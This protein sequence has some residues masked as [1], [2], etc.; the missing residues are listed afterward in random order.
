VSEVQYK[1]DRIDTTSRPGFA[2]VLADFWPDGSQT[3]HS[4]TVSNYFEIQV[5]T[6]IVRIVTDWAGRRQTQSGAWVIP[7]IEVDDEWQPR[8]E[9]PEDP[10]LTEVVA[11]DILGQVNEVVKKWGESYGN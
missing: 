2:C 1:I 7:V 8:P 11:L 10:W 5:R 3:E 6:E 4:P 9:S